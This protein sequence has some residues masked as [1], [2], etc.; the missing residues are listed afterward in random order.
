M[1]KKIYKK[2]L[3]ELQVEL[4]KFHKDVIEKGKKVCIIFEGEI[5]LEKMGQSNV[6]ANT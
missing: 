1:N 3:H 2:E 5:H 6:S 4:V